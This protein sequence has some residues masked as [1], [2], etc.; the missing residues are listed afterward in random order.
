MYNCIIFKIEKIKFIKVLVVG[1]FLNIFFLDIYIWYD[2]NFIIFLIL[3]YCMYVD[4][5]Y[6]CIYLFS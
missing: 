5:K 2:Y 3:K 4:C 6:V 1:V